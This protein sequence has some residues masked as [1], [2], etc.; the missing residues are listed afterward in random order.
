VRNTR[1]L[2]FAPVAILA[3]F[4][5]TANA[6]P[7]QGLNT[8]YYTIDEIP[9]VQS[10]TE[11]EEC[12][13]ELENNI[14]RSYDGEPFEN[15]TGDLF[16]VHMTGFIEIPE[17]ETIEFW[18]ASDDGGEAT[19]G[20]NSWGSWTDQGCSAT[21]SGNLVLEAGSVPLEVWMY[22]NG[23]GTCLMLAWKIDD[24]EW[25][26]VPDEAFTAETYTPETT[27]P[28]TTVPDTT[29][30]E[31][32]VVETTVP[33]TTI[34]IQTTEV[35]TTVETT[36]TIPSTTTS[37]STIPYVQTTVAETST[38][39]ASTSSSTTSTTTT[40]TSPI[41]V[42]QQPTTG[43]TTS[44]TWVEPTP[45][46][47]VVDT[48][49]PEVVTNP[50]NSAA[51]TLPFVTVTSPPEPP[52][53]VPEPLETSVPVEP[54]LT[55][56]LFPD[57]TE[58]PEALSDEQFDAALEDLDEALPDEVTAIVDT[59]LESDLSS[60]QATE[61]I[62]NVQVL[63][64]LSSDQA[65]QVFAEIQEAQLSEAAAETIAEALNNSDVPQE[66]KEAFE[67]EINIF[68]N[69]G[70]SGYVPVDSNVSVAVRRTI[71]AGTTVLVAMPPP[72]AR[73]R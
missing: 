2:I 60:E 40:T 34:P 14:N 9:P 49:L 50:T 33:D 17:H 31:T 52:E 55:T 27:I 8:T 11:Y 5:P 57:G 32:T 16:M 51:D 7:I 18:L 67:D 47:T 61:L 1:W 53:S 59:L 37:S 69:D 3:L 63:T 12:G 41:E 15:C 54:T 44:T 23:G 28:E 72:S 24:N 66:V 39:S 64:A 68:G 10:T 48:T 46:T 20:G 43:T 62:T 45:E 21:L 58:L 35:S 38:T 36:T 73:R 65:T 70:F 30:P 4:A 13:S 25:E 42:V 22:E 19:I 56:L 26:I 29:I 71:I 6:E